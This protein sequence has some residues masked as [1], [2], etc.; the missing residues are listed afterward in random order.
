VEEVTV[1]FPFKTGEFDV[2]E[3]LRL[4]ELVWP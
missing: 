2:A 3:V 4:M 1:G